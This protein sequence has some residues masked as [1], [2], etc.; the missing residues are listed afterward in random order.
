MR[1]RMTALRE[2]AFAGTFNES[3]AVFDTLRIEEVQ[4]DCR[5]L[6][7]GQLDCHKTMIVLTWSQLQLIGAVPTTA[8]SQA[9]LG[10]QR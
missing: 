8:L 2:L 6:A 3:V 5:R 1:W 10:M 7:T 4:D 9:H